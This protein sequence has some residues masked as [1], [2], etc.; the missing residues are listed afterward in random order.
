MDLKI[1]NK[2]IRLENEPFIDFNGTTCRTESS[3]GTRT[4]RVRSVDE[5]A[6][7]NRSLGASAIK[8]HF[9]GEKLRYEFMVVNESGFSASALDDAN[10]AFTRIFRR[11]FLRRNKLREPAK[12]EIGNSPEVN[13]LANSRSEFPIAI[14]HFGR[15]I[16]ASGNGNWNSKQDASAEVFEEALGGNSRDVQRCAIQLASTRSH[17]PLAADGALA[18]GFAESGFCL[19]LGEPRLSETKPKT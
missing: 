17:Q 13:L 2:E 18:A 14:T 15:E 9:E 6:I 4:S 11:R 5:V 7:Y 3:G 10:R 19:W 16:L 8:A 1:R 12:L